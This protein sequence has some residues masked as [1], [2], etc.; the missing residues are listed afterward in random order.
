M[1]ADARAE[2]AAVIAGALGEGHRVYPYP[3]DVLVAPAVWVDELGPAAGGPGGVSLTATVLV[4]TDAAAHAAG[5]WLDDTAETVWRATSSSW[6]LVGWSAHALRLAELELPGRA[7]TLICP[8]A[9][10]DVP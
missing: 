4:V 2:L 5:R 6:A 10:C 8:V 3:P 7:V 1:I 9:P